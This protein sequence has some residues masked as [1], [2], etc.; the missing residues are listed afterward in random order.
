MFD[1]DKA[2]ASKIDD[3]DD[4]DNR[5]SDEARIDILRAQLAVAEEKLRKKNAAAHHAGQ[6]PEDRSGPSGQFKA[7]F[8][9]RF[10]FCFVGSSSGAA[11][12]A[13]SS[14]TTTRSDVASDSRATLSATSATTTNSSK[15]TATDRS[16]TKEEVRLER[17]RQRTNHTGIGS[18]PT[19]DFASNQHQDGRPL[20][21]H[22][23]A[24]CFPPRTTTTGSAPATS[25]Q[26]Q[27]VPHRP[28]RRPPM[29]RLLHG[30][31][32]G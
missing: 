10:L 18:S 25:N 24:T 13:H 8:L 29:S 26:P 5:L 17:E 14:T 1:D 19:S 32:G 16:D 15:T 27:R 20:F 23:Y 2:E 6:V 9:N 4:D 11:R 22:R 7:I 3:T 21:D 31:P 28:R 30:G 12:N